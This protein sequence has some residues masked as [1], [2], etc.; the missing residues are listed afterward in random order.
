MSN[1]PNLQAAFEQI[2]KLWIVLQRPVIQ[3]QLIA[4][5]NF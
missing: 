5:G 4:F 3:R 1:D 2:V